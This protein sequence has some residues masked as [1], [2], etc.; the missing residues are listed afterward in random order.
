MKRIVSFLI[1]LFASCFLGWCQSFCI[2]STRFEETTHKGMTGVK[3]FTNFSIRND[4]GNSR[5]L[6]L[7]HYFEEEN[8]APWR[9]PS[10]WNF[11]IAADG[12]THQLTCVSDFTVTP[13]YQDAVYDNWL[14][15]SFKDL[16]FAYFPGG[17]YKVRIK[18]YL[19]DVRTNT[20]VAGPYTS[21]YEHY[22]P[23]QPGSASGGT[24]HQDNTCSVCLGTGKCSSCN[25][26]G[27]K[28]N[29]VGK[30]QYYT[31]GVCNGTGLCQYCR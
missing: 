17:T 4:M 29:P 18:T 24:V 3:I 28:Y 11:S 14:F 30:G 12:I 22:M 23:G 27:Y 19:F 16:N 26:R 20:R 7:I 1:V 9:T 13:G 15:V 8:G 21:L 5:N 31:C 6:K 10:A 25:G 2:N